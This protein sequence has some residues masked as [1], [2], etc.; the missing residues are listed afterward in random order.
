[1][2]VTG[3]RAQANNL[4]VQAG[5]AGAAA[6]VANGPALGSWEQ[7]DLI[8]LGGGPNGNLVALRARVNGMYVCAENAGAAPLVANRTAIGSWEKFT[9]VPA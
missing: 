9:L 1:M 4:V 8:D 2:G 5:N 7:F 3:L 6:L